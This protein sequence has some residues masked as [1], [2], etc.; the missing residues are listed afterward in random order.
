MNILLINHYAGSP[1]YGME[2]RP[3]YL[4]KQWVKWGHKVTI[5]G[6]TYSH[7]RGKQPTVVG[8]I[9]EETINGVDYIWLK[10][11]KYEGNGVGRIKSMMTF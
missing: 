7:L 5:V 9:T 2:F 8:D 10:T 11:N 6:G 4:A 3:Y 1:K